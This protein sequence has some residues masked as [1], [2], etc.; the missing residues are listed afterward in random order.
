LSRGG[1]AGKSQRSDRARNRTQEPVTS[2]VKRY[3][4]AAR[5]LDRG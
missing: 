5:L 3:T 1:W 2:T 4:A